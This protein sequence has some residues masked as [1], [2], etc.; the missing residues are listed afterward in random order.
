MSLRESYRVTLDFFGIRNTI[1]FIRF[2]YNVIYHCEDDRVL[3]LL[4]LEV[5][6]LQVTLDLFK[7]R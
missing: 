2:P 6:S 1:L 7:Y 4:W 5:P 3:E